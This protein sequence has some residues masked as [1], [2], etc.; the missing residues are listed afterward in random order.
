ML[1]SS[2][3]LWTAALAICSASAYHV[4]PDQTGLDTHAFDDPAALVHQAP[5]DGNLVYEVDRA[6]VNNFDDD[7]D[8]AYA[9]GNGTS[10]EYGKCYRLQ[11][12]DLWLGGDSTA[13]NYYTFG[14]R[15][16]VQTFQLCK[17]MRDCQRQ[18]SNDQEIREG[19]KFYLWDFRGNHYSKNG[20][21]AACNNLG[22]FYAAGGSYKNYAQFQVFTDDCPSGGY[23][24]YLTL[25]LVGQSS[26]NN[27]LQ[28]AGDKFRNDYTGSTVTLRFKEVKCPEDP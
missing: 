1:I 25:N 3:H 12:D 14:R 16:N 26:G 22:N 7:D 4:P 19:G 10:L 17:N 13:W 23:F 11:D 5:H 20:E 6:Q 15:S 21:F 18:N 8:P 28:V 9:A 24:C 2:C 27:G